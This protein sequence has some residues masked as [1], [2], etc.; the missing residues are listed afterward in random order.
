[1]EIKVQDELYVAY[2]SNV[3]CIPEVSKYSVAA[4]KIIAAEL[5]KQDIKVDN[6]WVF[7]SYNLPKNGK[8]K[9]KIEFC[10]I[11]DERA[12]AAGSMSIKKLDKV[13]CVSG[14][15]CGSLRSLFTKGYAPLLNNIR[16]G[17]IKLTNESREIYHIWNGPLAKDNQIEI[18]FIMTNQ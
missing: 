8:E 3:L 4:Q 9:Y 13:S 2:V 5:K 14:C 15:Y 6:K 10:L 1:M 18:Q 12:Q 11:V 7:I 16:A 17:K